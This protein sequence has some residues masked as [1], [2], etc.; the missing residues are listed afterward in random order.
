MS[1]ASV[2][3]VRVQMDPHPDPETTMLALMP[4]KGYQVVLRKSEWEDGQLA[5]FIRPDLVY[6]GERV[7][8]RRLRGV[9]SQGLLVPAPE[10]AREG[11]DVAEHLGVTPYVPPEALVEGGENVLPPPLYIPTY[12]V[13]RLQNNVAVFA[14]GDEVVVTEK[15]DGTNCRIV[16]VGG[17]VYVGSHRQW[18]RE[19]GSIHWR[20]AQS[21][22]GLFALVRN[23]PGLVVYGEVYGWVAKLRYGHAQGAL[24]FAAFDIWN[25]TTFLGYDPQRW[26]L[27]RYGIPA[28]PEVYRGPYSR[29][30]WDLADGQAHKGD[31]HREGIVIRSVVERTAADG[32]RAVRKVV[33][34]A[35]L[36]QKREKLPR[37]ERVRTP[38]LAAYLRELEKLAE[39]DWDG[40]ATP[41][42]AVAKAVGIAGQIAGNIFRTKGTSRDATQAGRELAGVGE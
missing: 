30:L 12:D 7:T 23:Y 19:E 41:S 4:V 10:G 40:Y 15:V 35:Y 39:R 22:P 8:V 38:Q 9:A 3:V 20:G 26:L 42:L 34:D 24:S 2:P 31:H 21:A 6:Q 29:D 5:A 13:E 16:C 32:A 25:G 11:D 36:S 17:T 18:K 37:P 27:E 28:V 1:D 33:A 14:D